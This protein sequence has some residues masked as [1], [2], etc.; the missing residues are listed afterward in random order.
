MCLR[1]TAVLSVLLV[2]LAAAGQ[3]LSDRVPADAIVYVGWQGSESMPASFANTHMKGL[4]DASNLPRL[5]DE[6]MPQLI[7][8]VGQENKQ[9]AE[10]MQMVTGIGGPLWRH[11]TALYFTGVDWQAGPPRPRLALVCQAGKE[12]DALLQQLSGVVAMAQGAPFPIKSFRQGELVGV[13]VG[14]DQETMALAGGDV[15]PKAIA[16]NETFKAAMGQ[17]Q[18]EPVAVVYVDLE[19]MAG[20]VE[21]AIKLDRDPNAQVMWP[22]I[23]DALGIGGLKRLIWTGGF[24]GAD[25]MSQCFVAAP[26]PR[27]GLLTMLE[28]KP[29]SEEMLR[30][31]PATAT[32]MAAG[33]FDLAKLVSEI[34]TAAGKIDPNA[35]KG[36]DQALGAAQMALMM[37]VQTEFLETLGDEWAVYNDPTTMGNGFLGL[38]GLNRLNKPAEAQKALGKLE[39]FVD[40][41][42]NGQLARQRMHVGFEQTKAGEASIHYVTIPF[43]SPSWT[44]KDGMLYAGLYP[45]VVAAAIEGTSSRKSI[46]EN[47]QFAALRKRLGVEKATGISY[48]DL[49][50]TAEDGY[51]M[52]L[53]A[54][55]AGLGLAEIFGIKTPPMVIP[56]LS[57]IRPHLAPAAG[58]CWVDDAGWHAKS[59]SPFP[60]SELMAS[61]GASMAILPLMA[62]GVAVPRFTAERG[63]ATRVRSANNLRQIGQGIMLYA[64]DHAG[65]YPPDLGTVHVDDDVELRVFISPASNK[66]I[67]VDVQ[68]A[69]PENRTAWINANTDYVYLGANMKSTD[70]A[71]MV[72]AYEKPNVQRG[73]GMNV[74]YNDGHVEWMTV[75]AAMQVINRQQA[76]TGEK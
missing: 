4:L 49:P 17:V 74:L 26:S 38:T 76:K 55:Q 72:L 5:F 16:T 69:K 14:Y 1:I 29:V 10:A 68:V 43:V 18:K 70:P 51:Q 35:Q 67:P 36:I 3:P 8:R 62:V 39:L 30:Q 60:G 27:A 33:H 13:T 75:P 12:A 47:Q 52:I 20:I 71:D 59:V 42:I 9:V 31:I 28:A 40:N 19:A 32:W 34:R 63:P 53:L 50:R 6:L 73:Q 45:Q 23:R 22:K 21:Q 48:A 58:C 2:P 44:I 66:S 57:K 56:P 64:N 11:P 7:A 65:K 61:Q 54:S 46:L 37:N 24:D 41:A 25:W 15:G